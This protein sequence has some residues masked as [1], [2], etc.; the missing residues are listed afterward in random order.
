MDRREAHGDRRACRKARPLL[1]RMLRCNS[2]L[3]ALK[4]CEDG[5]FRP[6]FDYKLTC[7]QTEADL[8]SSSKMLKCILRPR[9]D[10]QLRELRRVLLVPVV[11]QTK[12]QLASSLNITPGYNTH[13][14]RLMGTHQV[15][16]CVSWLPGV[17]HLRVH[18]AESFS[19]I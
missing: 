11:A 10:L 5:F 8:A 3:S 4:P 16:T 14:S 17:S 6:L 1:L 2:N 12:T 9:A 15:S 7:R 18:C 13:I 19:S